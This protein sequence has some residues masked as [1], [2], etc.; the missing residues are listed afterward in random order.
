MHKI[1]KNK[2]YLSLSITLFIFILVLFFI[3]TNIFLVSNK[4]IQNIYYYLNDTLVTQNNILVVEIDEDTLSGKKDNNWNVIKNW[5][6][7]FP[8]DRSYYS[9]VID[10]L[11]NAWAWV[12]ALD[13]IFWEESNKESD[14]K[15]SNSIKEAWNI[16]LCMWN[17]GNWQM[18][19]PYYKFSDYTLLN[20]YCRTNVDK[21]NNI[22]YSI[23]PF[24]NISWNYYEHFT[25]SIL[26][27]YYSYF[28]NDKSYLT[29]SF[30]ED[31]L[32]LKIWDKIEYLK[33]WKNDN[34][35]LISYKNSSNYNSISFLDIYNNSFD[36]KLVKDKIIVIWATAKWIKDI[37]YTPLWIEYWV[38]THVNFLNTII[39][40]TWIKYLDLNKEYLI[41]ICLIFISVYFNL[42]K[43]SY[44][45]IFSNLWLF[46]IL[47]LL[48]LYFIKSNILL[49]YPIE[50]I[51]SFILSITFS[52]IIKYIIESI[53]KNKLNKALSEYVSK[54]IA[55]EIMFNSWKVKLDWE[56]RKLAIY[57]SDI[58]WF[59][60]ISEKF[61]P[62]ELV[63]FLREYLSG[64]SHI[65]MDE[66]WF[67]DKYEWDAIMALWWTFTDYNKDWHNAC[68]TALLQQKLLNELNKKWSSQGFSTIKV[69]V[70]LHIWEAIVWN[71]W[72]DGR[73]MEFTALWDNVNLASRLEWVNKQYG[74]YICV[75]EEVYKENKGDFV[76]R[77]LDKIKVKWKDN[78]V[79]IFE[80]VCFKDDLTEDIKSNI[81]NFKKWIELY[82]SM[83]FKEAKEVFDKLISLWDRPSETFS[84]RCEYFLNN[85]IKSDW[86]GVYIMTEK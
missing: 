70:W 27:A 85:P 1:L 52:N 5:L 20:G 49:N 65:I 12:I 33:S 11:N 34:S 66:K 75:S 6:W 9:T 14:D 58:E 30:Q 71:I 53:N 64:M 79:S 74:T 59:T 84:S 17:D 18:L 68:K 4:K 62:E 45:I 10:N 35:I 22:T 67:I 47:F 69:R 61:N 72:A 21:I 41:I 46:L 15:L 73:K 81:K 63:F 86:D 60:S 16:V 37:F 82:N 48:I 8:F 32:S 31:S 56:R 80:L 39:S 29:K 76:F 25:T 24:V 19:R 26:R 38:Y 28:Y 83:N 7:R 55:E 3:Y 36:P 57:F 42:S 54:D 77:Y 51:L 13:I 23:Y 40:K 50:I 43:N 44:I 2:N 78:S